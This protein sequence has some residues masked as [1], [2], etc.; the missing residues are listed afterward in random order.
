MLAIVIPYYKHTFFEETL[1]SLSNQTDKRFKVYIGD[2]ASPEDPT[3]L[4]EKYRGKFDFVYHRFDSNLGG[5]S[6]TQQWERCISLSANEEWIMILG[7]DDYLSDTVVEQFYIHLPEFLSK[8]N[9]VRFASR[10]IV[11]PEK[12]KARICENPVWE[13]ATDS[14]YRKFKMITRS[15]LSEYVFLKG[16]YKKHGFYDY[17]LA[18]NSDDRA[19]LDFSE[20]KPIYSI[21]EGLVCVRLSN[22][23]IT[24]KKDNFELKN[25]SSVAFYK[26]LIQQK[27]KYFN[28]YERIKIIRKY[29]YELKNSKSLDNKDWGFLIKNYV[30]NINIPVIKGFLKKYF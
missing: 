26:Y 12:F 23:N 10:T 3:D 5:I 16:V 25:A 11:E 29:H 18:W 4:L 13:S 9:V 24:G 14:F 15:S 8:T 28:K 27:I 30:S 21:N 17:P 19:W 22:L 6:L 20:D 2:D 7:D 1:L